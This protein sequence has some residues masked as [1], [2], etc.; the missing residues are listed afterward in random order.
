MG[1]SIRSLCGMNTTLAVNSRRS[2]TINSLLSFRIDLLI[3]ICLL[4]VM[5]CDSETS[6]LTDKDLPGRYVLH[7]PHGDDV[8]MLKADGRFDQVYTATSGAGSFTNA[9]TWRLDTSPDKTLSIYSLYSFYDPSALDDRKPSTPSYRPR[10]L[11][12]RVI[13]HTI[14]LVVD[15]EGTVYYQKEPGQG[16]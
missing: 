7:Y 12:L 8:L 9:G 11:Y 3:V 10:G 14:E 2:Q 6:K 15:S 1:P 4:T 5:G 16:K 13:A